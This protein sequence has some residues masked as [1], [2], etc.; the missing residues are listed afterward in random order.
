MQKYIMCL[1]SPLSRMLTLLVLCITV[2]PVRADFDEKYRLDIGGS[3]VDFDSQIRINS[4]DDSIDKEIDFED[5]V[6]FD[7]QLR[8]GILKGT[9][10]VAD[11]HRLSLLYV[12][13]KR[14]TE[15]TTINDIEV[16]GDIIRAGAYLGS[17]VKTHV[18]D[19][20]YIYSY[21]KRP[22]LELGIS[23]GIYWM[24]SVVELT[25][26][27]DVRVEGSEQDQF[28]SDFEA[29]QRLIAPLP[30][31]GLSASYEINPRWLTH[32]Y[33]R[34]FDVTISDI[35]GRILS[36]N[37]KTE[38]FITDHLALGA[39]YALFDLSVRHNGVVFFN[40]LKYSYTGL[41]AYL[42]LEY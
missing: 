31:L 5:D 20:E 21:Y 3:V 40:E 34:Y 22:N 4:R 19:I 23:A 26:A 38:Y 8:L 30:L 9:W 25:A 37:V 1:S 39:G 28:Y 10:R 16:E 27:G 24:N 36:L 13:I 17:S 42:V 32:A 29:N 15:Y 18:F 11:R 6:G 35:E 14:A 41:Q 33:A 2:L 12:P 7:S